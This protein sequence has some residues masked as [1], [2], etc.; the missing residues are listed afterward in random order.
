VYDFLIEKLPKTTFQKTFNNIL[1]KT[2][3]EDYQNIKK[4]ITLGHLS[5]TS[6]KFQ[7]SYTPPATRMRV[8]PPLLCKI[9]RRHMQ[10]LKFIYIK[11]NQIT[12]LLKI[13][14]FPLI[15]YGGT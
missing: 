7:G 5:L 2:F 12:L 6:A 1:S 9:P 14:F 13:F 10:L 4:I 3:C 15:I 11:C 8:P